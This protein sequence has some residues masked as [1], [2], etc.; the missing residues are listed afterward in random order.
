[1]DYVY[2]IYWTE[3]QFP[4]SKNC[5]SR[6][7]ACRL[8]VITPRLFKIIRITYTFLETRYNSLCNGSQLLL[9]YYDLKKLVAP[10]ATLLLDQLIHNDIAWVYIMVTIKDFGLL[11][12]ANSPC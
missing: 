8:T 6:I 4:F 11:Q 2:Y 3:S 9:L 7:H 10:I 5:V 1:M 12:K